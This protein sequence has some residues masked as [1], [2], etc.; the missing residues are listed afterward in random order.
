MTK[1]FIKSGNYWNI[2]GYI[3]HNIDDK[4]EILDVLINVMSQKALVCEYKYLKSLSCE[5][6]LTR[7]ERIETNYNCVVYEYDLDHN[8]TIHRAN[9][10]DN[11]TLKYNGKT[12]IIETLESFVENFAEIEAEGNKISQKEKNILLEIEEMRKNND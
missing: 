1:R 4:D 8:Q 12:I 5:E 9:F 6:L 7:L 2:G 11:R 10:I 3:I